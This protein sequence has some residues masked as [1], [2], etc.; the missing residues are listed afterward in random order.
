MTLKIFEIILFLFLLIGALAVIA[1]LAELTSK[2]K[3]FSLYADQIEKTGK[4]ERKINLA[5]LL[6]DFFPSYYLFFYNIPS[7]TARPDIYEFEEMT[8]IKAKIDLLKKIAKVIAI[9]EGILLM[10]MI[11][12]LSISEK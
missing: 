5:I 6:F 1:I 10:T 3:K 11:L 4:I 7:K 8:R 12:I 9:F 2:K